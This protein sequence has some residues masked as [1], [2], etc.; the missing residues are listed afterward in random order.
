MM[1][2]SGLEPN[3]PVPLLGL[4]IILKQDVREWNEHR[5][6]SCTARDASG[7]CVL[8]LW[9]NDVDVFEEGDFVVLKKGWCKEYNGVLQ[10]SS[11]RFGEIDLIRRPLKEREKTGL[12]E[13]LEVQM[14]MNSYLRPA[15][16][17]IR[18]R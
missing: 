17:E 13:S 7:E 6:C 3:K 9:N 8:S 10:V 16:N 2:V 1:D 4:E 5:V 18:C 15:I 11:G 12:A 14:P